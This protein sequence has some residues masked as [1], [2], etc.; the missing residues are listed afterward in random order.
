MAYR[1]HAQKMVWVLGSL[2]LLLVIVFLYAL[3][4]GAVSLTVGQMVGIV[5]HPLG[6]HLAEVTPVQETVFLDIRLPRLIETVLI[7]GALGL[8]GAALQGLFRNPLVEPGLVG[9]SSGAALGVVIVIVFGQGLMA[10]LPAWMGHYFLIIV[11]FAGGLVATFV[12]Y[13]L[14]QQYG[15]TQITLLL[16]AG[17]AIIGLSQAFIGLSIF[18]ANESQARTYMFWTLGDLG[19][20]TW[21]K[22]WLAIPLITMPMAVLLTCGRALN[23]MALGEAEA[24]HMGV[25]VE[26]LKRV[27]VICCALAVGATVSLAGIIGFI[28]LVVPHMVRMTFGADHRLVLPGS[29]LA[30]AI[31]LIVSDILGRTA[32]QPAELPIGIVTAIIG[33]PFLLYLIRTAKQK[34]ML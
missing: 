11:A 10:L 19:G 33:T 14:S 3:T 25:H 23:A 26:R 28:G 4:I 18:Y 32:V 9:V 5:L 29:I 22:L 34:Q 15:R 30:G 1:P 8:S 2:S 27:I 17:V 12:V 24:Y 31:L 21:E 20:A 13:G 7:G 6:I 16:L